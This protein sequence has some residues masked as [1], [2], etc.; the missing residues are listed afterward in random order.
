MLAWIIAVAA[1]VAGLSR[2]QA[3]SQQMTVNRKLAR[4]NAGAGTDQCRAQRIGRRLA[5]HAP[6]NS[7]PKDAGWNCRRHDA[8][9]GKTPRA[10]SHPP[11]HNLHLRRTHRRNARRAIFDDA[12]GRVTRHLL[13][14]PTAPNQAARARFVG[15]VLADGLESW[16]I[17][18]RQVARAADSST[19][20]VGQSAGSSAFDSL[21]HGHPA[22]QPRSHRGSGHTDA[23]VAQATFPTST[24]V[25]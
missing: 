8:A 18:N 5:R 20:L 9:I 1:L 7:P 25:C 21:G 16:A 24:N 23:F 6:R 10:R 13:A 11:E 12:N 14:K 17:K 22:R 3:L 2:H 15:Q 4:L 19:I